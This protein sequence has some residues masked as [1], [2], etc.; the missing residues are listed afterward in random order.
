MSFF[1]YGFLLTRRGKGWRIKENIY[2]VMR[3]KKFFYLH[4]T[5]YTDF[6]S[7]FIIFFSRSKAFECDRW[8]EHR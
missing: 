6:F 8:L 4:Y 1:Q 7:F 2:V 3:T 5:Y